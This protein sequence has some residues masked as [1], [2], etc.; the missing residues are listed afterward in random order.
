MVTFSLAEKLETA[1]RETILK[2]T[3][4]RK[5]LSKYKTELRND[6]VLTWS[7]ATG[8]T[9]D[10][11]LKNVVFEILLTRYLFEYTEYLQ[12]AESMV[13]LLHREGMIVTTEM[14]RDWV[15]PLAKI[16][17]LKVSGLPNVWPW[18]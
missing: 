2:V 1:S 4:V 9:G 15:L 5:E 6:S 18:M 16:Q 14:L 17:A 10:M 3:D 8:Q 7:Y 11:S 13:T 12:I